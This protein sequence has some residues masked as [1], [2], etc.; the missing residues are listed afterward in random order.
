MQ[1]AA[2]SPPLPPHG[3]HS[4]PCGVRGQPGVLW[5]GQTGFGAHGYLVFAAPHWSVRALARQLLAMGRHGRECTAETIADRCAISGE[6]W[7]ALRDAGRATSFL[8]RIDVTDPATLARLIRVIAA[9]RTHA[10]LSHDVL[11][12]GLAAARVDIPAKEAA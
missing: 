6:H 9:A 1:T 2:A 11:A 7:A 5:T 4:N 8:D 12:A 10:L 3:F